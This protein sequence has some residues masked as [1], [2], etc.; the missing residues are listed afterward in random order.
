[1]WKL[2]AL[3]L[4]FSPAPAAAEQLPATFTVANA[5]TAPLEC[6]AEAGHWYAFDLGT[7]APHAS[8]II[9]LLFDPATKTV[10]KRNALGDVLP[11]ETVYCGLA[12]HAYETRAVLPLRSLMAKAAAGE[13]VGV[14]CRNESA[15]TACK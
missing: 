8:L 12:G 11:I 3:L 14:Q 9:A 1:M 13:L 7:A 15:A 4:A 5:T 10:G 2:A 6:Q